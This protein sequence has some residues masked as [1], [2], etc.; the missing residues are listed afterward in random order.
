MILLKERSYNDCNVSS[1][2]SSYD[3]LTKYVKTFIHFY[4]YI[5]QS[6]HV[7]ENETLI[8][9]TLTYFLI[10]LKSNWNERN[11]NKN[12]VISRWRGRQKR[13]PTTEGKKST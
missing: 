13:G 8:M 10:I 11:T 2:G 9:L 6:K 12:L 5:W 7:G 3:L 4:G 1:S